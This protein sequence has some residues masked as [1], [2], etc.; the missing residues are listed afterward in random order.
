[1]EKKNPRWRVK[2]R[3]LSGIEITVAEGKT[4]KEIIDKL[5]IDSETFRERGERH[6]EKE[7]H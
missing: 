6:G 7:I 2:K 4:R 3:T 5:K 1:M